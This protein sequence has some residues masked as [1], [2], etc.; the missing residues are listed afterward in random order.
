LIY[1]S[2]VELWHPKKRSSC[3]PK[4]YYTIATKEFNYLENTG[5]LSEREAFLLQQLR[6]IRIETAL[7][8]NSLKEENAELKRAL[9]AVSEQR[10]QKSNKGSPRSPRPS[11]PRMSP[12]LWDDNE[13][14]KKEVFSALM[15]PKR[16]G[17]AGME[18][19][20]EC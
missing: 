2:I 12:R 18:S 8:M 17:E 20:E 1:S 6:R 14:E 10:K 4:K 5:D 11:S 19:K 13:K 7:A 9:Q 16:G 3:V 15:A